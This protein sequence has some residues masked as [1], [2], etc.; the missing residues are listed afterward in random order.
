[1]YKKFL[2]IY[3]KFQ[4][5]KKNSNCR[6]ILKDTILIFKLSMTNVLSIDNY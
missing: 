6:K 2:L 5:E 1:M 4:I 3:K